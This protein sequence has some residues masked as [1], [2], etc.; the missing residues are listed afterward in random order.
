LNHPASHVAIESIR[1]RR[2]IG[3][4]FFSVF[5][6]AWIGL[7]AHKTY[8][9]DV[10][11]I[12]AVVAIALLLLGAACNRFRLNRFALAAESESPARKRIARIFNLVNAGQW[13]VIVVLANVL[14][15]VG[16]AVWVIPMAIFIIGLHFFPLARLF[17]NRPHY[18]TGA[19]LVLLAAAYPWLSPAG[20]AS[21]VGCLGA[22]LVLWASALWA[23][24]VDPVPAGHEL[25][26]QGR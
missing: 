22:G 14:N 21:A 18:V 12:A 24:V 11:I 5:G 4:M 19:A 25:A 1:A 6:G 7:W 17:S 26:V 16:L 2:A 9:G 10:R 13:I 3:A 20:P 23:V 15:N 8:A